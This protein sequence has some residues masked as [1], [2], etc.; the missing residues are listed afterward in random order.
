MLAGCASGPPLRDYEVAP[1]RVELG[2]TPFFPQDAY[3]CGPAA[4][5]TVLAANG[6][7]VSPDALAPHVYLPG[8]RGS[9]QAEIVA[10]TRRY[11]RVPYILAPNLQ[12]LLTEVA[13]GT[14]V[15]VMQNL[16]LKMLPQ[17]HYAVVIGYDA[18]ADALVLRSGT[19][20]R[21]EMNRV[22]FQGTWARAGN[23][24]MV[25]VLP[26]SPPPTANPVD[27]LRA[28]S[29]FEQVGQPELGLR[30]YAA[31]A[32]RWPEEPLGWQA[33]AN[34]RY[35]QGDLS[36]A[37][38]ALRRALQLAPSAAAHNNLAHVLHE[39]GC[40]AAARTE[41][42]RG[43][44]MADTDVVRAVLAKTRAVIDDNKRRDTGACTVPGVS[45]AIEPRGR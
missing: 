13:A 12:A 37:E 20:K 15:L 6:V 3:Q 5:A 40:V 11:G 4:L 25:A 34:A 18:P 32:D 28:A 22:R 44:D 1:A 24:A 16:G 26:S 19:D 45:S 39:R 27:W 41:L 29:D 30:A 7:T 23:W 33:L 2:N 31:A 36:A 9:L 10:A 43:E 38:A 21:L 35:A 14:P 17:W 42:A 8:R